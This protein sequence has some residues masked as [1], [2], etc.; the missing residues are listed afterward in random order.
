MV[1][2]PP[3]H[4][5]HKIDTR[6]AHIQI[7]NH[8]FDTVTTLSKDITQFQNLNFRLRKNWTFK[9]KENSNQTTNCI[10][11]ETQ[12]NPKRNN[13]WRKSDMNILTTVLLGHALAYHC[14]KKLCDTCNQVIDKKGSGRFI[15]NVVPWTQRFKVS[16]YQIRLN[17]IL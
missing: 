6:V 13:R 5:S 15:Y 11:R 14:T 17:R 8:Q 16:K 3:C 1:K 2:V 10:S 4:M 12:L 7:A 9:K